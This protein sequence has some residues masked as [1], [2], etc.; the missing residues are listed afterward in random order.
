MKLLLERIVSDDK[1][2]GGILF[3]DGN[4]FC[5]TCE[6]APHEIKIPGETRIP[7]GNYAIKLRNVG[8]MT[9]KYKAHFPE[10]HEGML[11]LQDVEGFEW[12]YIHIGN[13]A[14]HSEGC[15]LVG[16]G[17]SS[18]PDGEKWVTHSGNAYER[19]YRDV[20]AAARDSELS[21]EIVDRDLK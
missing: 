15:I 18:D 1:S 14:K 7:A 3:V 16:E 6:D 2:T 10:L 9:V 4:F 12:I 11:W 17:A 19:L 20:V 21:I 5:H 8:G 13:R